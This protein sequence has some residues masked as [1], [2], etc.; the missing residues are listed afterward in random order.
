MDDQK[1]KGKQN[2]N[3]LERKQTYTCNDT[4]I[5]VEPVFKKAG[6]QTLFHSLGQMIHKETQSS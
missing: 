3:E 1:S 2:T 4:V 5:C 6:K